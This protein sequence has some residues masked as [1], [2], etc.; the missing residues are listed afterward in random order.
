MD[1]LR[2]SKVLSN[3]RLRRIEGGGI[4]PR[5]EPIASREGESY[6]HEAVAHDDHLCRS[7]SG[8][9]KER[10]GGCHRHRVDV[11]GIGADVI[12][13]GADVIGVGADVIGIG[14][15]VREGHV[16]REELAEVD[17]DDGAEHEHKL[18]LVRVLALHV[19]RRAQY[20]HHRAHAV[21]VVVLG[22]ELLGAELVG[23]DDLARAVRRL[24]VAV[25]VEHDLADHG[26]VRH[27]HRLERGLAR[28]SKGL[29]RAFNESGVSQGLFS[30]G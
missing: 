23:G 14:V 16:V 9:A 29:A 19:C 27:H 20:R 7:R 22:G 2:A 13:I 1:D 10:R 15:D 21:V 26:V 11:V 4:Y 5:R 30:K 17:V 18:V 6:H 3:R 25:G 24:E 8:P 12:G 28:V